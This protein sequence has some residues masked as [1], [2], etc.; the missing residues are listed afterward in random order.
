MRVLGFDWDEAN[1][2]KLE[3]HGLDADDIEGHS[4]TPKRL[5]ALG[6]VPDDRF[7]LV[8]FEYDRETRWVRVVTAYEPTNPGW[9]KKYAKAK[10]IDED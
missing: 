6:F 10:G 7:V 9:W 5:M 2:G 4:S 8:I 1:R 3:L